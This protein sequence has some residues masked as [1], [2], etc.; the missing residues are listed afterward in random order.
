MNKRIKQKGQVIVEYVLLLVILVVLGSLIISQMASRN[1]E[2]PGF[3]ISQWSDIIKQIGE[4]NPSS[5]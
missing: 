1:E 4:D 5:Y 2:S 3:L